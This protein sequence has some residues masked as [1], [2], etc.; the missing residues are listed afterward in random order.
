MSK[1]FSPVSF[2]DVTLKNRVVVSP[3][4]QYSCG[5]DG[6]ATP[7]HLMHLGRLAVGGASLVF[8]EAAAVTPVGRISPHDLG[9]W[10]DAHVRALAPITEFIKAQGAVAGIQLAHAGRKGSTE[11]PWRGGKAVSKDDGGYTPVG[12]TNEPFSPTY[13]VPEALD[14]AGIH[15]VIA[16]FAAAAKRAVAAG[17]EVIELHAAHGYLIHQFL[18]PLINTRADAWGGDFE[19][20]TKLAREVTAAVRSALPKDI[21]L[22]VRV[23]ATD[24]VDGGWG[25]PQTVKL[26]AKLKELGADLIDCSS[27]GAV[28]NA[29]IPVGPNYQLPFAEAVKREVG[30]ATGAVGMIT[31]PEQAEAIVATGK[32]DVVLLARA[33]LHDPNWALHAAATLGVDVAW[34][35]PFERAKTIQASR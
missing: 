4:C 18:S 7:W 3:M 27:G 21:P 15:R 5:V 16:A 2:R 33:M 31:G 32:A 34:P 8:T 29:K 24:W 6:L 22:F 11:V 12:A 19:G 1:L 14:E 35:K 30:I 9:I 20:R 25:L 28:P 13:P 23:S 10:S 26:S 17:F